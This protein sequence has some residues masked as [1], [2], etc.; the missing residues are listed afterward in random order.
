MLITDPYCVGSYFIRRSF[1]SHSIN[2]A[3]TAAP[4]N[5]V[6]TCISSLYP[7]PYTWRTVFYKSGDSNLSVCADSRRPCN[8]SDERK[9]DAVL[10]LLL[11]TLVHTATPILPPRIRACVNPPMKTAVENQAYAYNGNSSDSPVSLLSITVGA[12]MS[13]ELRV[14]PI[15]RPRMT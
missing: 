2:V 7:L 6:E 5:A 4:P 12:A 15:P 14:K 9:L 11:R 13:K 8:C 1:F 3:R 10:T